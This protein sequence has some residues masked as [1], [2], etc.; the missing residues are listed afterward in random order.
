MWAIFLGWP[1]ATSKERYGGCW[2]NQSPH[3]TNGIALFLALDN[4]FRQ[5]IPN[6][7]CLA[8]PLNKKLKKDH[9]KV[10]G[11]LYEKKSPAVASLKAAVMR[12]LVLPQPRT[13]SQYLLYA[14]NC[15]KYI[16]C[17]LF[18]KQENGGNIRF[19]YWGRTLNDKEQ[20][21]AT[22]HREV[23]VVI[24]AVALMGL[25]LEEVCFTIRIDYGTLQ[26]ILTMTE[27]TGKMARW[28]LNYRN[29]NSILSTTQV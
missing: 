23:L 10:F 2:E 19:G 15:D 28:R 12:P 9:P 25:Y 1:P 16:R 14:H 6:F 7:A 5:F 4:D 8:T 24:W 3:H 17:V 26:C 18:Q 27:D 20:K 29:L 13:K 11:F 21:L 22:T